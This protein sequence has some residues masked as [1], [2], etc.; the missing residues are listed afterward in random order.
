MC[1]QIFVFLKCNFSIDDGVAVLI[2]WFHSA[3]S[4]NEAKIFFCAAAFVIRQGFKYYNFISV[5]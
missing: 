4:Y 5:L 1:T 2:N 3:E